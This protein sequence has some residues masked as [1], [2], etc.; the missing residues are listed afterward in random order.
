MQCVV[1]VSHD[2]MLLGKT[3][4]HD[5]TPL[6]VAGVADGSRIMILG[7]KVYKDDVEFT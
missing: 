5:N 1:I 7:K 2:F 6:K 3:L 4:P